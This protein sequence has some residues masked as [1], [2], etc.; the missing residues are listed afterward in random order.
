VWSL[1][2]IYAC[3][4]KLQSGSI[5]RKRL[6]E[7]CWTVHDS[8]CVC[9]TQAVSL[10][11]LLCAGAGRLDSL[12]MSSVVS[13]KEF[14]NQENF[15]AFE[16]SNMTNSSI[17]ITRFVDTGIAQTLFP[18]YKPHAALFTCRALCTKVAQKNKKMKKLKAM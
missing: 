11:R 3:R 12:C 10:T 17:P 7:K 2:H 5:K 16:Q 8:V 1:W 13:S 15:K 9:S 4:P 14:C 6:R 18:T